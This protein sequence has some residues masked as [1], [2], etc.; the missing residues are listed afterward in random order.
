MGASIGR[1]D[2]A[3]FPVRQTPDRRKGPRIQ[4]VGV[5]SGRHV[6]ELDRLCSDNGR[7]TITEASA[8]QSIC[9]REKPVRGQECTRWTR[10]LVWRLSGATAG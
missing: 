4:M 1:A 9:T 3:P 6:V 8:D 2:P 10:N 7:W 5:W